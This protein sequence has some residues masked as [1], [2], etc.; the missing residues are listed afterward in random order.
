[1]DSLGDRIKGYEAVTAHKLLPGVPLFIRVDGRAFHTFTRGA[2]KPF[3]EHLINAMGFATQ[4][5][6]KQMSG[7]KLA[8][9]Q[10]DEATFMLTD[11]DT[12]QTQG[13]FGYELSKVL[14]VTAST[15]TA[16]FNLYYQPEDSPATFD[17]RAFSVPLEDAPNVFIW[18]QKDWER[19]SLQMLARSVFSHKEL[20]GKRRDDIHEMLHGKGINWAELDPRLKNGTFLGR[21]IKEFYDKM[22]YDTLVPLLAATPDKPADKIDVDNLVTWIDDQLSA[23]VQ[24]EAEQEGERNLLSLA[25]YGGE[26]E[27]LL[28]LR[29]RL[30]NRVSK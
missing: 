7:F 27:A 6:A 26:R 22:T 23:I 10:S 3:D 28:E 24:Y 19:N 17:A 9:T 12:Y 16:Y 30:V 11:Y 29:K 15:F 1:M 20:H 5:T 8:Y 14:S 21:D 18:R 13:W 2:D 25:F 4:E